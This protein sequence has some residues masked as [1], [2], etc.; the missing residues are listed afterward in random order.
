[1]VNSE[2]V[3]KKNCA[4]VTSPKEGCAAKNPAQPGPRPGARML[5]LKVYSRILR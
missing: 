4:K 3:Y 1:M 5:K 2:Q